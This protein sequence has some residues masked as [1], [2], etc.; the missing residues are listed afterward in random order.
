MQITH[1]FAVQ[2]EIIERFK[3][4]KNNNKIITKKWNW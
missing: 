3:K 2:R 1:K 4:N